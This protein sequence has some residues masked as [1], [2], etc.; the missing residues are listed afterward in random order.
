MSLIFTFIFIISLYLISNSNSSVDTTNINNNNNSSNNE[1]PRYWLAK[2]HLSQR[3]KPLTLRA[4]ENKE[5]RTDN[6]KNIFHLAWTTSETH[7]RN[8]R[9]VVI[10]SIQRHYRN[11]DLRIN[12]YSNTLNFVNIAVHPDFVKVDK[13]LL[14]FHRID[15]QLFSGTPLEK[16]WSEHTEFHGVLP[17]TDFRYSHITDLA[18]LAALWKYGGVYLDFDM[19]LLRPLKM[20]TNSFAIQSDYKSGQ[21]MRQ[22]YDALNFAIAIFDKKHLFI[23][24]LIVQQM[25]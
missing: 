10:L 21:S 17:L 11:S 20:F 14:F 1:S 19:V 13:S 4:E 8:W 16:W 24:H 22:L 23:S 3:L 7:F 6:G 12:I 15:D 5:E 9:L 18:R 2:L 25:L